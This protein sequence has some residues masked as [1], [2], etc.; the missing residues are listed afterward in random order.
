M[1]YDDVNYASKITSLLE[2]N[3]IKVESFS[4]ANEF[5]D[6]GIELDIPK[7]RISIQICPYISDESFIVDEMIG[8][9]DN[10]KL[11][12]LGTFTNVGQMMSFIKEE[13]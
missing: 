5:V 9:G 4:E 2:E 8:M 7:R 3:G 6:A 1:Y 12:T 10:V 13:L 11:K